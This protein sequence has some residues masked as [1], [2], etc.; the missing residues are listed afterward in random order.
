MFQQRRLLPPERMPQIKPRPPEMEEKET[1]GERVIDDVGGSITLLQEMDGRDAPET[2]P[3]TVPELMARVAAEPKAS[4]AMEKKR[5][6]MIA[7]IIT[8][9]VS[10]TLIG[11]LRL[12]RSSAKHD[13]D[14]EIEKEGKKRCFETD[15]T[16]I[17]QVG[18]EHVAEGLFGKFPSN[19]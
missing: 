17:E 12:F 2:M 9:T 14:E 5:R 11:R 8:A 16:S 10:K 18:I 19:G 1:L 3:Q 13:N 15:G 4:T 7:V 6:V